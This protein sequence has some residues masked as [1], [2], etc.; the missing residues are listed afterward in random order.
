M[1]KCTAA[2]RAEAGDVA[3]PYREILRRLILRME[4]TRDWAKAGLDGKRHEGV[5]IIETR[6]QLYTPLLA[7]Y[8]SLCDVGLDTIANGALLDTLRRVAVF[9]VT[10]TKLDLRQEAS[11]H[12]QVMEELTDAL[13]LGHYREWDEAQRQEFLLAELES[14]RPLIPRRWECSTD[15]QAWSTSLATAR[16]REAMMGPLISLAM[17]DTASKSPGELAAKPASMIS[18]CIR[19]SWRAISIFS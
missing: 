10:L 9:G 1:W 13:N 12:A 8:R 11:R 4:S 5:D 6:E 7:C 2:L 14:R 3:E 19:C 17:L 16:A 18:T 15:R